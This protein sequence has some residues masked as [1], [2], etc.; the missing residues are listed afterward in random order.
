MSAVK[1][2]TQNEDFL[3]LS[4]KL[5]TKEKKEEKKDLKTFSTSSLILIIA[6]FWN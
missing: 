6:F 3:L 4:H 5:Q 2:I 1:G